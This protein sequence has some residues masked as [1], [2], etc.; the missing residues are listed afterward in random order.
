[1]YTPTRVGPFDSEMMARAYLA[2]MQYA[3][4]PD[5]SDF[6]VKQESDGYYAH[7]RA[8]EDYGDDDDYAEPETLA[9]NFA[10]ED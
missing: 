7:F 10:I 3:A 6:C 2:G 8:D 9:P 5:L 4:N 1:M